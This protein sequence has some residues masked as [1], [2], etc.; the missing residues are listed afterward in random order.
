[1][2]AALGLVGLL[3]VLLMQPLAPE[4]QRAPRWILTIPGEARGIQLETREDCEAIRA[5]L[6]HGRRI[7][8]LRC[9]DGE[10][11]P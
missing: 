7:A 6:S 3:T 4:R 5:E 8:G 11:W 9:V 10:D 2:I 1:M